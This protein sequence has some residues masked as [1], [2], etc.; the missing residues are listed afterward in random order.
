MKTI[1]YKG[2]VSAKR[3]KNLNQPISSSC[4]IHSYY[5]DFFFFYLWE[6]VREIEN[7]T[8]NDSFI[9]Y[10]SNGTSCQINKQP[11]GMLNK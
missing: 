11:Q 4:K 5:I 9:R 2:V 3:L 7:E 6:K 1:L 10:D 8:T